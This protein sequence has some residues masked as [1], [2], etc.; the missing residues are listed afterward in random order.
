[1]FKNFWKEAFRVFQGSYLTA[2]IKAGR[3]EFLEPG[4]FQ[5]TGTVY[6]QDWMAYPYLAGKIDAHGMGEFLNEYIGISMTVIEAQ[7]GHVIDII[8]DHVMAYFDP[9]EHGDHASRAARTGQL[10][11]GRLSG[12][13]MQAFNAGLAPVSVGL[14]T[15]PVFMGNFGTRERLKFTI[16]GHRVNRAFRLAGLYAVY[17][18]QVIMSEDTYA[19]LGQSHLARELD[20][21]ASKGDVE[22]LRIY[23][24]AG[25]L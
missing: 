21:I 9:E 7:G 14:D 5:T 6:V 19:R 3:G 2:Q 16:A 10:V 17:G 15:G 13:S 8:G 25:E 18:A 20:L 24:Y 22:P 1:M 12:S 4:G 23:E 11:A